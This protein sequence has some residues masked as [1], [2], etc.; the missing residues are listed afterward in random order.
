[1]YKNIHGVEWLRCSMNN[2]G[3]ITMMWFT[4]VKERVAF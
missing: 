1:M 2:K 4:L 3:L